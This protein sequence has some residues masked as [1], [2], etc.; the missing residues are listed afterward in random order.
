MF[1]VKHVVRS[2]AAWY[3]AVRRCPD[4]FPTEIWPADVARPSPAQLAALEEFLAG[5]V[6][7]N[8]ELNLTGMD[9]PA[10]AWVLHVVDSASAVPEVQAAPAGALAD[11]GSGGGFP[12]VPLAVLTGRQATLVESRRKKAHFLVEALAGMPK[13]AIKVAAVRAEELARDHSG[14]YSVVTVRAVGE[15]RTLVELASPLLA[16]GGHLVAMKGRPSQDELDAGSAAAEIVGMH[17]IS[18][19]ETSLPEL[20]AAR[21]MIVYEKTGPSSVVLPR[22]PGMAKKRPLAG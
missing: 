22:R 19:R 2:R 13:Y 4:V 9:D 7:A 3:R 5:V 17:Q 15:L 11:I 8:R 18:E 6:E 21:T 16:E 1:H 10:G 14:E 20:H 12:G